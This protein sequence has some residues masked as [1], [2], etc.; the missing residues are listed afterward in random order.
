MTVSAHNAYRRVAGASRTRFLLQDGLPPLGNFF[1]EL[2]PHLR[3]AQARAMGVAERITA[4]LSRRPGR[5]PSQ[6]ARAVGL[7]DGAAAQSVLEKH[8]NLYRRE[9]RLWYVADR[10]TEEPVTP[11]DEPTPTPTPARTM[12]TQQSIL[13]YLATHAPAAATTIADATGLNKRTVA[14]VLSRGI[15]GVVVVGEEGPSQFRAKLW[16]IS[17]PIEN[18][19]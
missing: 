10:P 11:Q 8:S 19:V 12:S 15:P 18:C 13:Q 16:G 7:H 9:G 14:S 1:D 2:N 5:T 4:Y 17:K 6:I 3:N